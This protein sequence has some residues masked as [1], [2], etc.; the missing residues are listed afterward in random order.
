MEPRICG[1]SLTETSLCGAYLYML[2]CSTADNITYTPFKLSASLPK[3]RLL[4]K[5]KI[6]MVH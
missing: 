4:L 5:C 1:P 3:F 6:K 2:T